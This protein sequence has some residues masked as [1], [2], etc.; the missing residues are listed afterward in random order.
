MVLWGKDQKHGEIKE[1]V[2]LKPW[3]R[4]SD[5][6]LL[7]SGYIAHTMEDVIVSFFADQPFL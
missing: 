1:K 7:K 2:E 4:Q 3:L 6:L 5:S